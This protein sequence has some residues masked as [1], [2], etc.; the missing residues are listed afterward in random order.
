[1]RESKHTYVSSCVI[2]VW[3]IIAIVCIYALVKRLKVTCY[4]SS[5]THLRAMNLPYMIT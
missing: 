4:S 2:L 5:Q 3:L 1:M